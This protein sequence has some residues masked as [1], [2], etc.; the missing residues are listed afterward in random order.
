[1]TL[2][3]KNALRAVLEHEDYKFL[4]KQLATRDTE[5]QIALFE[6]AGEIDDAIYWARHDYP[7]WFPG[8][9]EHEAAERE[10]REE[11]AY[12]EREFWRSAI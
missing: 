9:A 5:E 11:K 10:A 7:V 2:E 1:M 12:I 4:V 8:T 3:E 6:A